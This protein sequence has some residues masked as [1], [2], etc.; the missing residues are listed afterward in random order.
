MKPDPDVSGVPYNSHAIP[1]WLY[2]DLWDEKKRVR[3]RG[4]WFVVLYTLSVLVFMGVVAILLGLFFSRPI[5]LMLWFVLI[6]SAPIGGIIGLANWWDFTRR[7]KKLL[8][9]N[10][11]KKSDA[12]SQEPPLQ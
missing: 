1:M 11:S 9:E 6:I 10:D 5:G 12:Q 3:F 2:P 8:L 7:C 4:L